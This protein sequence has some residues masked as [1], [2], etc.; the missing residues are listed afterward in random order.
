VK[1]GALVRRAVAGIAIAGAT[2]G[3]VVSGAAAASA[4]APARAVPAT[5]DVAPEPA[6]GAHAGS[7]AG[8][9]TGGE[10]PTPPNPGVATNLAAWVSGG[11]ERQLTLLGRDFGALAEASSAANMT[12][13]G[14]SCAQLKLDV[15]GAQAFAPIPDTRAQRH[16]SAALA[17]YARGAA[18]CVKGTH[19]SNTPLILR[20]A[21]EIVAGSNSLD[22][23]TARLNQIAGIGI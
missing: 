8:A 5:Q 6:A 23:V 1:T 20:A 19:T 12:R 10:L 22:K 2:V 4:A 7:R 15:A 16:W 21:D 11:G 3:V 18:D 9:Q 14:A 17:A 13:M